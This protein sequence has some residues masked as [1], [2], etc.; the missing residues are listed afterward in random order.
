MPIGKQFTGSLQSGQYWEWYTWGWPRDLFVNWSVRP[1]TGQVG[2]VTLRALAVEVVADGTLTYHLTVWNVSA[3]PITFD[4]YY[5]YD[6]IP[7]PILIGIPK[8]VDH[9]L[10]N[11]ATLK[12]A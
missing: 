9:S 6:E 2:N 8:V 5:E 12:P 7:Q 3:H 4:A 1:S 11:I 10:I